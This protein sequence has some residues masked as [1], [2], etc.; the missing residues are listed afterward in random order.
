MILLGLTIFAFVIGIIITIYENKKS[1]AYSSVFLS[2]LGDI[3]MAVGGV[4]LA[5][6]LLYLISKP[7]DFAKFKSKY[8]TLKNIEI[9]ADDL[10]DATITKEIIEINNKINFNKI[11]K[12]NIWIG[13]FYNEEISDLD[14][15]N[16]EVK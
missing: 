3:L 10:R 13:I 11:M 15:L 4:S 5:I 14:L 8:D 9:R 12:D 1:F 2:A 6:E 7:I 16:K